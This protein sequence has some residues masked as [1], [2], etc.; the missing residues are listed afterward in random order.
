[1]ALSGNY[2][3]IRVQQHASGTVNEVVAESTSVDCQFTA[4]AMEKT[5]KSDALETKYEPGLCKINVSGDYL[6]ASDAEQF[7]NL[8]THANNGDKIEVDIY[9]SSTLVMSTEGV[10]TSLSK[11]GAL[12]DSLVTGAYALELDA[13]SL[14]AGYG[15]E[16]YVSDDAIADPNGSE[17]NSVGDWG[18]IN[19]NGTGSNV[20]QSQAVSKKEGSYAFE[21]NTNDTPTGDARA[22]F[23]LSDILTDSTT[24]RM[25]FWSRH[26]GTGDKWG[27]FLGAT[28][29]EKTNVIKELTNTD[30]FFTETTH[31]F[32]Y[33]AS[34]RYLVLHEYSFSNDG[35][36]F[37]DNLSIKEVL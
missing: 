10:F 26:V 23:D 31:E 14:G 34:Y 15:P 29:N 25:T 6:L 35:G 18:D 36:M 3:T 4:E 12:S 2:L 33:S 13:D 37:F 22:Y 8:F 24:Y 1:M 17:T 21:A 20:F 27:V 19:I 16:L 30:T 7:T 5:T 9:R 28:N 11:S 32:T